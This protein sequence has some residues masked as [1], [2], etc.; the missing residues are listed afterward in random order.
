[1]RTTSI[2]E[3]KPDEY[4]GAVYA[5]ARLP[6]VVL[7][8]SAGVW[9]GIS[10]LLGL[11]ASLKFHM[12]GLL[13]NLAWLTYGRVRPAANDAFLYGFCLQIA[14]GVSLWLISRLGRAH[15]V[16]PLPTMIGA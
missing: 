3:T 10:S 4:F 1:M 16:P 14:L 8:L 5:T 9:L 6:L 15:L 13:A 7:F 12:P 11:I 2:P